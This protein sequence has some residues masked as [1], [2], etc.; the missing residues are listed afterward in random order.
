[1]SLYLVGINYQAVAPALP[2]PTQADIGANVVSLVKAY[3]VGDV[4][5]TGYTTLDFSESVTGNVANGCGSGLNDLLDALDDLRGGSD[6]IYL[7]T[8]PAGILST[9]GNSVGGCAPQGG[10]TAATFVD[11]SV[12]AVGDVPHEV[13][14][15]LDRHHAPCSSGC[16]VS[17]ADP[18]NNY[19]QYGSFRSDSIGVFGFDPTSNTVFN[20]AMY[21]DFMAY[22]FPQWVSA[23]TYNGLR[24][25][26]FQ[27]TSGAAPGPAMHFREDVEF[28]ILWLGLS[29]ARDRTVT[30][31]PSFNF[32][33]H[34]LNRR[35][36]GQFTAELQ[37]AKRQPLSCTPLH[38]DCDAGCDCWPRVIRD[39]VPLPVGATWLVIWEGETKIFEEQIAAPPKVVIELARSGKNGFDLTWSAKAKGLWYL[40]HW[41][42]ETAGTWRGVAPR[43]QGTS[44]HVPPRLF[45]R[46]PALRLRVLATARLGTGIAE[47]TVKVA[48]PAPPPSQVT[49]TGI[50]PNAAK[51]VKLPAV[52]HATVLDTAGREWPVDRMTWYANGR[53]IGRG[54]QVDL[55]ALDPGRSDLRVVCRGLERNIGRAWIIERRPDGFVLQQ[56][57]CDPKPAGS[58]DDHAHPHPVPEDPCNV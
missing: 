3:P 12:D 30:L 5:Q 42:D 20:P 1:M 33:G 44:L 39:R 25:S 43:Q 56:Q 26:S 9:P 10:K 14:H 15:A 52:L 17:P 54:K 50:D 38:C 41:F 7:G 18:D 48:T 35:R 49:L 28:E 45:N 51:P 55:R 29:I 31:R 6:D 40:V 24:G 34:L 27:P 22:H 4:I 8:L 36:C 47:T 53:A 46:S 21:S 13:G 58:G 16:D 37:D 19:P 2:A 32:S 57:I 11:Y 23:Y